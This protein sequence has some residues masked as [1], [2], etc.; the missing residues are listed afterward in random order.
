M[1]FGFQRTFEVGGLKANFHHRGLA[2]AVGD[3]GAHFTWRDGGAAAGKVVA[4]VADVMDDC[5]LMPSLHERRFANAGCLLLIIYVSV[6]CGGLAV[7]GVARAVLGYVVSP[8]CWGT[9]LGLVVMALLVAL[10]KVSCQPIE[11]HQVE[12]AHLPRGSYPCPQCGAVLL[13]EPGH[14]GEEAI[15]NVC[16]CVHKAPAPAA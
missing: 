11:G 4:V 10:F 5:P 6:G 3:R 8:W 14:A 1:G 2:V 13:M 9:A 15:C 7:A 12:H 16:G